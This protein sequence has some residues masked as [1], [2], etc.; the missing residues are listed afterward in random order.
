MQKFS[1]RSL[2][3][4]AAPFCVC[5][6]VVGAVTSDQCME[7]K[8]LINAF[9]FPVYG[10]GCTGVYSGVCD[11]KCVWV[12]QVNPMVV[13]DGVVS[14]MCD[15]AGGEDAAKVSCPMQGF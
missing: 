9:M 14:A 15:C 2:C 5:D 1:V 8:P 6:A 13:G 12:Y 10:G 11:A 7:G 3:A 4:V